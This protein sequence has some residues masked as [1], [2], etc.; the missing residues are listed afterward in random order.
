MN[1][2][3]LG[4][5]IFLGIILSYALAVSLFSCGKKSTQPKSQPINF[6]ADILPILQ[7][8][9]NTS[10]CHNSADSAGGLVFSG[11]ESMRQTVGK[12]TTPDK[13]LVIPYNSDS[14]HLVLTIRRL[15]PSFMPPSSA[16]S[17]LEIDK[18]AAWI[19]QGAK[20]PSGKKFPTFEQGKL[21]VA[22]SSDGTVDVVDLSTNYKVDSIYTAPSGVPP[23]V[24]Q[25]HHLVVSPDKKFAYVTNSWSLGDLVKIDAVGDSVLVRVRAG[26]QPADVVTSP[27]GQFVYTTDYTL[28]LPASTVAVVRKFNTSTMSLVDTFPVGRAPHGVA[29]SK[30]GSLVLAPGQLSDDCWFILPS[31]GTIIRLKLSQTVTNNPFSAAYVTQYEPFGIIFSQNDSLAYVSCSKNNQI[32]IINT[33]S[34]LVDDIDSIVLSSTLG[35]NPYMMT[36][37]S[38][39]DTLYVACRGS[40]T[41]AVIELSSK[42]TS[43][44]PVGLMAHAT[45]LAKTKDLLYVTCE[46]NH[47]DPYKV[48]V[49][50]TSTES[51]VDSIDVGRYPNGIAVLEP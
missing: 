4:L 7:A 47:T 18:F 33:N 21:Y 29:I 28:G 16:L 13:P 9:C 42:I 23:T 20:D 44:V 39:A 45:A 31:N 51:V 10:G 22:N 19:Q 1:R 37:S 11:F 41:V 17:Q 35:K 2:L 36:L 6:N 8:R 32:R 27:D 25:T 38:A 12:K 15:R 40:N 5:K 50:D 49:I 46:G 48:Y 14:S 3:S 34:Q 30:D 43:Y 26:Y 24:V